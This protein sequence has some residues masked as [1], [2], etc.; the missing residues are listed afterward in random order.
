[1]RYSESQLPTEHPTPISNI[2]SVLENFILFVLKNGPKKPTELYRAI[3]HSYEN[4]QYSIIEIIEA[5]RNLLHRGAI[6]AV[7]PYFVIDYNNI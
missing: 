1:M 2:N 3:N 5:L 4:E 7:F 6:K